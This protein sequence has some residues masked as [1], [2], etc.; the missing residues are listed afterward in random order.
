MTRGI[1]FVVEVPVHQ[2]SSRKPGG[3]DH[4]DGSPRSARRRYQG[5]GG[6]TEDFVA[7]LVALRDC[8]H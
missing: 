6:G 4:F 8:R 5:I 2:R 1:R 3:A 7:E